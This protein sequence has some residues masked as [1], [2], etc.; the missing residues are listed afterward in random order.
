MNAHREQSRRGTRLYTFP[1]GVLEVWGY[2][3]EDE[4]PGIH[5]EWWGSEPSDTGNAEIDGRSA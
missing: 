3:D 1:G 4:P 2:H 5:L